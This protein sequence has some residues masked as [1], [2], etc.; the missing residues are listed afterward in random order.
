M[1]ITKKVLA[2][3]ESSAQICKLLAQIC[4]MMGNPSEALEFCQEALSMG[5][6]LLSE[7]VDT[8]HSSDHLGVIHFKMGDYPSAFEAFQIAVFITR[9]A[10]FRELLRTSR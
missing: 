10:I 5:L 6:D 7:H 4:L 2:E 1:D 3:H 9:W 8:A